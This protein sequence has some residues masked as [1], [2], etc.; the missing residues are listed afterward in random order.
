MKSARA[1]R[2]FNKAREFGQDHVFRY[3]SDLNRAQREKLLSQ[4]ESIDLAKLKKLVD[5]YIVNGDSNVFSGDLESI[6]IIPIPR[7]ESQRKFAEKAKSAGENLLYA[8]KVAVVLVAGGQG[9]RLGFIGPKGK[10]AV[11]PVSGKSLYQLHSEKI[12][13]LIRKYKQPIVWFIMTSRANDAETRSF[14]EQNDFFGLNRDD[15]IF[16]QQAMIPAVSKEGKLLLDAKEHI[17]ENPNGHGGTIFAL[18][19]SG[20]LSLMK[21]RGVEHIFYFQVDNVLINICDPYFMG[22]H[23]LADAEMSAKVTAKRDPYEKVGVIGKLNGK[24]TVIEYSD[25]STSDM[26]ARNP[27]GKLKYNGGSIAIH[28]FQVEFIEKILSGEIELPYHIANKN[29]PLLEDERFENEQSSPNG[30]KFEMFI[31]DA[32]PLTQRCAVMEVERMEEFSPV[33]NAAQQDSPETAR[34]DLVNYYGRMLKKA[35]VDVPFDSE[36]NVIGTVEISPCF[37]MDAHE[38]RSKLGPDFRFRDNLYLK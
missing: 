23:F 18:G 2:S 35:G 37:A 28:A 6:D 29:I 21:S 26:E 31:F 20:A 7:S 38:L 9:T 36:G 4:F 32:L 17:F 24:T 33:K 12:K 1:A 19:D 5:E 3:W 25:L 16:F 30:Y 34:K 10:F 27:D 11:G 15:V 14:F 22:Y 8:G 13:A